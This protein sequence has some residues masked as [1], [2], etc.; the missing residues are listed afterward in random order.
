MWV[1]TVLSYRKDDFTWKSVEFN[2]RKNYGY[3][4]LDVLQAKVDKVKFIANKEPF[5]KNVQSME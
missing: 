5:Y 1:K 4:G 2:L 3:L